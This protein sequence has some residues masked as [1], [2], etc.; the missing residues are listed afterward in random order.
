MGL[1]S[2]LIS[3]RRCACYFVRLSSLCHSG[4][5]A[6]ICGGAVVLVRTSEVVLS[7]LEICFESQDHPGEPRLLLTQYTILLECLAEVMLI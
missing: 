1:V 4:N 3:N 2:R 6:D 5:A 7:V